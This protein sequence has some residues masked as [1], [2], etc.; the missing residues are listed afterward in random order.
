M[1]SPP[2]IGP[3]AIGRRRTMECTETPMTCFDL[4]R[5]FEIKSIEAGREIAVQDRNR[6]EP[7]ITASQRGIATTTA[8][9]AMASRSKTRSDFFTPRRSASQPPGRE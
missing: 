2:A 9:P 3:S 1:Q 6:N 5:D 8:K 7:A 4:G